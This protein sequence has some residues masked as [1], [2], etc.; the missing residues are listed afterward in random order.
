MKSCAKQKGI[1]TVE[2][3]NRVKGDKEAGPSTSAKK[4]VDLKTIL[5]N[6]NRDSD[7]DFKEPP[8]TLPSRRAKR[9][10]GSVSEE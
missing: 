1:S 4:Q 7:R 2:L 3:L 9:K 8:P 10:K 6:S 5:G